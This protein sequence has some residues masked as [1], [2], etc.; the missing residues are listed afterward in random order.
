M[1]LLTLQ[2]ISAQKRRDALERVF[3]HDLQDSLHGLRDWTLV[4]QAAGADAT[5][6]TERVLELANHLTADVDSQAR[7]L[8]AEN[9]DLV[10]EVSTVSPDFILDKLWASLGAE[11]AARL[12]RMPQPVNASL[13]R[14]DPEILC[15]IL[16]KMALNALEAL[17]HGGQ[18]QIW[19]ERRSGRPAFVVQNSGCMVPEVADR[20]FQR[21]F[22]TKA[23]QGR[24]MG[25]YG[26]KLLGETVL[27][28]KVGFTT[29]W[30][31][32]TRF[33][34]ELPGGD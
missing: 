3:I 6:M 15:R 30:T 33:F 32:G 29:N 28:G 1:M 22:S 21:S 18:A 11:R 27:G 16:R 9:G 4:L 8:Q 5:V 23:D 34:I 25:T 19:H 26:M 31:E 17:P 12:I 13:L 24:G 20:V 2:D 10:P 7:L 14:T